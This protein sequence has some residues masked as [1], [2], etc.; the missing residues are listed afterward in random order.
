MWAVQCYLTAVI[1]SFRSKALRLFFETGNARRLSVP[2]VGRVRR[3][4]AQIDVATRP[5]EL[6][7]PGLR[8]H[9]LKGDRRG[10]YALNA[11]G[12]YRITFR[13]DGVDA[14]DVDLEDYH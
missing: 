14:V 10:T 11:S 6:D 1:R 8:F 7:L 9:E 13:W 12:N 2:N 4:L 3:L 5:D